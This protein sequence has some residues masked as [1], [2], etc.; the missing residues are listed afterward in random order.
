MDLGLLRHAVFAQHAFDDLE[1]AVAVVEGE[2]DVAVLVTRRTAEGDAGGVGFK[3]GYEVVFNLAASCDLGAL[4]KV[5]GRNGH[6]DEID[7]DIRQRVLAGT[8]C[9]DVVTEK[10]E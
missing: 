10:A 1:A 4:G 5:R 3:S 7:T 8:L 2:V 6:E 9:V